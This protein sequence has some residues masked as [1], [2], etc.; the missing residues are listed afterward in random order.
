MDSLFAIFGKL[1]GFQTTVI[2][3][4][5]MM[6]LQ[7]AV[8]LLM[9]VPL[10]AAHGDFDRHHWKFKKE[11]C[12]FLRNG[13]VGV[14]QELQIVGMP[15]PYRQ[16]FQ[17]WCWKRDIFTVFSENSVQVEMLELVTE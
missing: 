2:S 11:V 13:K 7:L 14:P 8:A 15:E 16:H 6:S 12:D 9:S 10:Y 4:Y 5:W 3:V 17:K 1:P